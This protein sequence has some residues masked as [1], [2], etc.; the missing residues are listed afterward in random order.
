M[1][2]RFLPVTI[3][4]LV[5]LAASV[6]YAPADAPL[7][8]PP[9][10]GGGPGA[11]D[12]DPAAP[13]VPGVPGDWWAR[14]QAQ[15]ESLE[16]Q[17]SWQDETPFADLAGG[18]QAPNRAHGF[19]T[20]FTAEGFRVVPRRETA[21]GWSWGLSLLRWGR[22]G[23]EQ[24]AEPARLAV[25]DNR[26][27]GARGPLVEWFVNSPDGL[28]QGFTI[29]APP[30]DAGR[31][32]P[33]VLDLAL[34]GSLRP[35]LAT[36]GRAIDFVAADGARA[37]HFA[38]LAA[39][40]A[41]GR[42]LPA[43]FSAF[44]AE[45]TGVIRI[46]VDDA[47]AAYPVTID[48]LAT[49]PAWFEHGD[50]GSDWYGKSVAG[51]GDLN[52][53]GFDDIAVGA[54][55]WDMG[56]T[57]NGAVF[58]YYGSP[59]GPSTL[60]NRTRWGEAAGDHFGWSVAAAG[61]IDGD[62]YY[63]LLVGAPEWDDVGGDDQ[64]SAY[65][66]CGGPTSLDLC[67]SL[68]GVV[69]NAR[70]GY[71]VAAAG[72]VHGDGYG[73]F[74]VSEP[75]WTDAGCP[76]CN[77][78]VVLLFRGS[79]SGPPAW[80]EWSERSSFTHPDDGTDQYYGRAIGTAGDVN[81]DGYADVYIGDPLQRSAWVW[82]GSA[83]GLGTNWN[84]GKGDTQ[85]GS[86]F[87][88]AVSAAGDVDSDGY[89]DL[90]VGAPYW[91]GGAA[92]EGAVS[93]FRG[94]ASGLYQNAAWFEEGVA[95]DL[96]LGRAVATAGDVDGD[97]YA[98]IA[99]GTPRQDLHSG[100]G[101]VRVYHGGSGGPGT[102]PDWS[103]LCDQ[104]QSYLGDAIAPAGDVNGDGF[105][106]LLVGGP[107]WTDQSSGVPDHG[108]AWLFLGG[109]AGVAESAVWDDDSNQATAYFGYSV[110][111]AGDV[112][113]DGYGDVIVGAVLFDSRASNDGKVF[114]YHGSPSGPSTFPD[115]TADS[116]QAEARMGYS[117]ASAGDVNGDGYGDV[118]VGARGYSNPDADEGA[119]FV[120]HGSASGLG[121]SGT[122]ANADWSAEGAQAGAYF[123][124]SVASA[125][126]VNGD[127]YGDV[128]VGAPFWDDG[129]TD[130]G[131][132]FVWHGSA[133][134][135]G[136]DST[137]AKADWLAEANQSG[138]RFGAAV[139]SAGDVNGDGAGD[140]L[141]G[142][143][144]YDTPA[145]NAG[146][147]FAWHGS[148][149]G[150]GS[151]GTPANADWSFENSEAGAYFGFSVAAA[152]DVNGDAYGDVLV[153]AY[154]EDTAPHVDSGR[155][156]AFHGSASGLAAHPGFNY[157]TTQ[158]G[159]WF[160]FSV[161][162]AGDVNGDGY[163][164]ALVGA[165]HYDST[166]ADSGLA[167]LFLGS[168]AGL[169]FG[170]G[171]SA[172]GSAAGDN[173]GRSVA[174]A[175]DVNGDG[176]ADLLVGAPEASR[177]ESGEGRAFLY[178]GNDG[179]PGG[180]VFLPMQRRYHSNVPIA[181]LGR[182]DSEFAFRIS[183]RTRCLL[184]RGDIKLESEVKAPGQP[185]DGTGLERYVNWIDSGV[186]YN[187]ASQTINPGAGLLHWRV[188][189][190]YRP[191]SSP[192][193]SHGRWIAQ[194]LAGWNDGKV[195]V[196]RD[197][198]DDGT[199]DEYDT[200]TDWDGDGWGDPNFP[201]NTCRDD[202][203][204]T[205]ATTW[206]APTEVRGLRL[207]RSEITTTLRW[208]SPALPGATS[209]LYDTLRNTVAADWYGSAATCLESDEADLAAADPAVPKGRIFYYLVRV[210]NACGDHLG[211]D[212]EGAPRSGRACP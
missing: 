146:A 115:W 165:P 203:R 198:D 202:C 37:I 20:W 74:L 48:P 60:P 99:I 120:W 56:L 31:E 178:L 139:S 121:A 65:L 163:A 195:R 89:S 75:G 69:D 212:S 58:V 2:R 32:A 51:V 85:V 42:A 102:E 29:A 23:A 68:H 174:G 210:Q 52:G 170:D 192:F 132:A 130:E 47:G 181:W 162:G 143:Y 187:E 104:T 83:T 207:T 150:L 100:R 205:D 8:Q 67:W 43:R 118:I 16:Y 6:P 63:D 199:G 39:W 166:V 164:D 4:A 161:A 185:F 101:E 148:S 176:Y 15:I 82:Y 92:E 190:L 54:P 97:G 180:A 72:D 59:S 149:S 96:Q 131:G 78:G 9:R 94:S 124:F 87:G 53:D 79:A 62:G 64:G 158:A 208:D 128:I 5:L 19:R 22:A 103:Y 40:D 91:D 122:P 206:S 200:C 44:A 117:V 129:Q 61:D 182:S 112:N 106:D 1:G 156:Y 77:R 13:G 193:Q 18:W 173:F 157:G 12:R 7:V 11:S 179:E 137:P 34:S 84:W 46:T 201:A 98:D 183:A 209:V 28:E 38:K 160:G 36:D 188:R 152:G 3:A 10:P 191:T 140:V 154:L 70:F 108:A 111:S 50:S 105:S 45:E 109:P 153:G 25:R 135:L 144:A 204:P 186:S 17:P 76:G 30:P 110:A 167:D 127:G 189:V 113:G 175:G 133:S 71:R 136:A 142:A 119:A 168:A 107:Y 169:S 88:W 145:S 155:A 159:G 26:V 147:A 66:Y 27:D 123:G 80:Q 95:A 14:A 114:V 55:G 197:Y 116:G 171:W 21:P 138:A 57:D 125:G 93:L 172:R 86:R 49:S 184:G 41:R 134:G 126:D 151:S 141:V 81:G 24:P 194:P 211:T 177:P 35:V 90:V 196:Y 33:L 73:D